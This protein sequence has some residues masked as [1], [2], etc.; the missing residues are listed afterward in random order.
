ME[1]TI[2]TPKAPTRSQ[3][4]VDEKVFAEV[5]DRGRQMVSDDG[6]RNTMYQEVD[7]AYLMTWKGESG[8]KWSGANTQLIVSPDARNAA[9]GAVRLMV[10]TDPIFNITLSSDKQNVKDKIEKAV[11]KIFEA[12][13]R[14][15][16]NPIHYDALLSAILYS[17]M[18]I[19]VTSTASLVAAAKENGVGLMRAEAIAAKTP[20]LIEVWN[21]ATGHAQRDSLVLTAYYREVKT[22]VG[23][24]IS[25]F[26]GL[27][28]KATA[29]R[30]K[31]SPIT[32]STF[33]DEETTTI[34]C[35][36]GVI[37][38]GPH[39][40]PFIPVVVQTTEGSNLWTK[41]EEARQPLLYAFMKSGFWKMQSMIY[42]VMYNNIRDMGT[43]PLYVHGTPSGKEGKQLDINFDES[44]GVV[45]VEPGETFVPVTNKGLIDP[46]VSQ[47]LQIATQKGEEST[48]YAQALG[49]PVQGDSTFSELALLS[50]SGRLPLIGTQK[51]GGWGMSAVAEMCLGL[52][53][54]DNTDVNTAGIDLK[55]SD[56]TD[57]IMID[58]KLDVKLPQDKLQQ[59]NIAQ[60]LISQ[61]VAS[62]EWVRSNVLN[63]NQ[64]GDMDREIWT[65]DASEAM[66]Q[67]F[68]QQ[69]IQQA[70]AAQQP[71]LPPGQ[72]PPETPGQGSQELSA[73]PQMAPGQG[74]T[75]TGGL[76]PQMGGMI[77]G[78]GQAAAVPPQGEPNA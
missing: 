60:I 12:A 27:L 8:K 16:G 43:T 3:A 23:Q 15:A 36:D 71:Q 45:T 70:Q 37:V 78:N 31:S 65:E 59:A 46:L 68:L 28:P 56:L 10:A 51:R 1:K 11:T 52:I 6:L 38:M 64:S 48:I 35:D 25:S 40:L 63:I 14:A 29:E 18:H 44:P 47:A 42:T 76:P 57:N 24:L 49:A 67:V 72:T 7:E 69:Q 9:Q 33:Y 73:G 55:A 19:A 34:W 54:T 50:Q 13:G 41:P 39:G 75:I 74:E 2:S 22:T 21:P 20:F 17:E 77:P 61:K 62:K 53:K 4:K 30:K 26:G 5:K 32:L 58:C 66:F